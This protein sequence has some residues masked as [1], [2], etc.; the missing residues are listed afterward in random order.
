MRA[1]SYGGIC[2]RAT[3]PGAAFVS[4]QR[5]WLN[6]LS[7]QDGHCGGPRNITGW[8]LPNGLVYSGLRRQLNRVQNGVRNPQDWERHDEYCRGDQNRDWL[9]FPG[10]ARGHSTCG[11]PSFW[12]PKHHQQYSQD[13]LFNGLSRQQ[14]SGKLRISSSVA[15]ATL[16]LEVSMPI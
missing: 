15:V 5:S 7:P 9:A 14:R 3:F 11:C 4:G 2:A 13:S 12:L 10:N 1:H 8:M 16:N 6:T